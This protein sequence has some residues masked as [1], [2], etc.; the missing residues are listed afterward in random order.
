MKF[1]I[2]VGSKEYSEPTLRVGMRVAKAFKAAVTI[3]YVGPKINEFTASQVR[4]A[5]ERMDQWDFDRP[6]VD[7]L[8]WA[9]NFLAEKKYILPVVIE[10]GFRKNTLVPTGGTRAELYLQGTVCKDVNLILRNGDIISELRDEVSSGGF[11]VTIIGGSQ[12]RRM[13]HNLVQYINSSIFVVN[14][15]VYGE[16]YDL[17]LPVDDSKSTPRAVRYGMQIAKAFDIQVDLLTVSKTDRFGA[18]YRGASKRA[19]KLLKKVGIKHN[20]HLK[21]GDPSS[22][23]IK[24]AGNDHIIVM[25]VSTKNPLVKFLTGSKPLKVME[26]SSCP[27]LIVK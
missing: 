5:Q 22:E 7:V 26:E 4:L 13:A 6:G 23:I 21:T 18:G 15:L 16:K 14:E 17:L 10:T 27:I 24:M 1:L 19:A 9:F 25:G 20:I 3:I 8:N 12:K 2:A 11:D